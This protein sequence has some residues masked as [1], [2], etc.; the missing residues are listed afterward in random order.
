[1]TTRHAVVS[2][3]CDDANAIIDRRER[4]L[5]RSYLILRVRHKIVK[6]LAVVIAWIAKRCIRSIESYVPYPFLLIHCSFRPKISPFLIYS[7]QKPELWDK[8]ESLPGQFVFFATY[9]IPTRHHQ[10]GEDYGYDH[11]KSSY[12]EWISAC[13]CH[14]CCSITPIH[15]QYLPGRLSEQRP[16]AKPYAGRLAVSPQIRLHQAYY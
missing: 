16:A 1:M 8:F 2:L 10:L 11:G 3:C 15:L 13:R 6:C 12:N 7:S 9:H 14:K 4:L 5:R